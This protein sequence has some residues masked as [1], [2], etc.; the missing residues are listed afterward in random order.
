VSAATAGLLTDTPMYQ[1]YQRVAPHPE[2][3]PQLLDK[4]GQ[5]MASDFDFT[6]EVGGLQVPTLIVAADADMAPRATMSRSSSC[7]MAGSA[8]AAGWVR[9]DPRAGTPWPSC[10]A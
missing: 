3:F 1:L 7:S 5:A 6:Q 9:A 8:T 4:L 2:D 10:P